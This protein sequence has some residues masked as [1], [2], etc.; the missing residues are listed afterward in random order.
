MRECI[1][2][3]ARSPGRA[4]RSYDAREGPVAVSVHPLGRAPT[5]PLHV[6]RGGG[7]CRF[8]LAL[9]AADV[10]ACRCRGALQAH[11]LIDGDAGFVVLCPKHADV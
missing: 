6:V 9:V 5:S 1:S 4:P 7:A 8:A 3:M 2:C 10:A 11:I